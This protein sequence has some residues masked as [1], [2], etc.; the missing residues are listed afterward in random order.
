M[1]KISNEFSVTVCV[2]ISKNCTKEIHLKDG[3]I[4]SCSNQICKRVCRINL[5]ERN[6]VQIHPVYHTRNRVGMFVLRLKEFPLGIF[7][8]HK[9]AS[10]IILES[11]IRTNKT[12]CMR[13][14][15]TSRQRHTAV[16]TNVADPNKFL[17]NTKFS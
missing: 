15:A 12:I 8:S 9:T 5:K 7:C 10:F 16:G 4:A 2:S 1:C 17:T 6:I 14:H 3:S 11:M 13:I